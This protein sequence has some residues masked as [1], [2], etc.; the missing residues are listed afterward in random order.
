MSQE[1]D[2]IVSNLQ[3]QIDADGRT[4]ADLELRVTQLQ[5]SLADRQDP[6]IAQLKA[7]CDTDV[8]LT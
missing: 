4:I 6:I 5:G 3:G 7:S 8:F 1:R 2:D